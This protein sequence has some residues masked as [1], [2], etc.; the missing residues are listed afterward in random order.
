M[1]ATR[2]YVVE[3][4]A[5]GEDV[6]GALDTLCDRIRRTRRVARKALRASTGQL[7]GLCYEL[8]GF[9]AHGTCVASCT[10]KSTNVVGQSLTEP[11]VRNHQAH[12]VFGCDHRLCDENV[13]WL[14]VAVYDAEVVEVVET[15]SE[16]VQA[17]RCLAA[18]LVD[19]TLM[20][21]AKLFSRP[22]VFV[23]VEE[24]GLAELDG[25]VEKVLVS[26]IIK[27]PDDVWMR[28]AVL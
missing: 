28:I 13:L 10:H 16:L 7:L 11:K 17:R 18:N 19:Q 3:D 8:R 25:D 24:T 20:F 22:P 6:Y 1:A 4:A 12:I 2:Q 21:L 26:F 27:V 15:S 23:Q 9:P 14:D 5:Q